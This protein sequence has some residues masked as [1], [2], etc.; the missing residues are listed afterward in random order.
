GVVHRD[1]KPGNVMLTESG[2]K[3]L[4]FGLATVRRGAG[5]DPG[6]AET[7]VETS[8]GLVV[9]TVAYMSP[10]QLEGRA[11]DQRSD[12]FSFGVMLYEMVTGE[13]P[14]P[15]ATAAQVAATVLRDEPKPLDAGG[16]LPGGLTAVILRCLKRSP[17]DRFASASELSDALAAVHAAEATQTVA[18]PARDRSAQRRSL[19][20][21]DLANLAHDPAVGWLSTGIAET[22]AVELKGIAGLA[23]VGREK[24]AA[25]L[26]GRDAAALGHSEIVRLGGAV[27]A[28]LVLAGGF[29]KSGEAL[30]VT[31][32]VL[33]VATGEAVVSCKLDGSIGA[34]FELQDRLVDALREGLGATPSA[35]RDARRDHPAPPLLQAYELYARGRQLHNQLGRDGMD[36][37]RQHYER[38]IAV[39]PQYALAYSGLG[40]VCMMRYIATSNRSD[41]D[42]GVVYLMRAAELD[43]RLADPHLWLT[44]GLARLGRYAEAHLQGQRAVALEPEN[45]IAHYFAGVA[46]WL[47]GMARH[48]AGAWRRTERLMRA[49]VRLAPRYQAAVQILGEVLLRVGDCA[50]AREALERAAEIERSGKFTYGRF[51]GAA[52]LLG[53]ALQRCEGS[54]RAL[55]AYRTSLE[56]LAGVDH[57]YVPA[58]TALAHIGAGEA[59]LREGRADEAIRGFRLAGEVCAASRRALGMGWM[60]VR[61]ALG[62]AAAA[63]LLGMSRDEHAAAARAEDLLAGVGQFDFSGVMD[64][65]EAVVWHDWARY[66]AIAGRGA[67]AIGSLR[68]AVEAG[69]AD[70]SWLAADEQLEPLRDEPEFTAVIAGARANAG[71]VEP[72]PDLPS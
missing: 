55:A 47:E 58:G 15:G 22:V 48:S 64:G 57:V 68:R 54:E 25:E 63:R 71:A 62:E 37:A 27:G 67:E 42:V 46:W 26:A 66:H 65:G 44:Y 35:V 4:D 28:D 12:V 18:A 13:R 53:R 45:P 34:L 52:S 8:P 5:G 49:S 56:L 16:A 33:D 3:L 51:V 69:W 29:Q 61:A 43:P 32:S 11:V 40:G 24:V 36:E 21:L 70:A 1:L 50:G 6:R 30:R 59:H 39:D 17:A 20:V 31:A 14:F 60:A 2:V 19:L 41:L 10:E 7:V 23:M 9:G 38:A 72:D